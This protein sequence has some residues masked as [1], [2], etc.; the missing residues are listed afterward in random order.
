LSDT[1][2]NAA[3]T[4]SGLVFQVTD[5]S[6]FT[7][8]TRSLSITVHPAPLGITASNG[9]MTYGGTPPAVT[10]TY[11]GFVNG[12]TAAS[13]TTQPTCSTTATSATPVGT[14]SGADTCTG[15]VDPN[16]IISYTSGNAVVTKAPLTIT[17]SNTSTAYGTV[18][19]VTASYSGFVNGQTNTVLTTQPT[20]S[21]TV[22]ATTA[23]G[24][25]TGANTCS[26]AAAANYSFTYVAGNATV[27]KANQ[28]ISFTGPGAGATGTSGT[29]TATG[30]AS[31]NPVT[32]TV[33]ATSGA[34]VCTVTG[35]TTVNYLLVGT[36][37]IDANQ[38]ANT[39]YNAATQVPQS[40][41]VVV[42][43][44]TAPVPASNK[45]TFS[46]TA[47]NTNTVTIWYCTPAVTPCK[48]TSP[49]ALSVPAT[50]AAGSWTSAQVSLTHG[51]NNYTA[52]AYQT[53]GG[54]TLVST[55]FTMSG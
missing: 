10:A 13:L 29:L 1:S 3:G 32:F 55:T 47:S 39:N 4:T 27:V 42:F 50:P 11:S 26:G 15:A 19:T 49:G 2:L 52:T 18:P 33:D 31:G 43:T 14:D 16:Y 30:G 28:T 36:C 48:S 25:S 45:V 12:D 38:A 44:L 51:T 20:C 24:T 34:G 41:T 46:G 54:T 40:I 6:G 7:A 22:T 17:A 9:T 8:D 37:V 35:G 5:A 21:S 23:V 53:I